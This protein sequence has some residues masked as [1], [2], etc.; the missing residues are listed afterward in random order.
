MGDTHTDEAFVRTPEI[1]GEFMYNKSSAE[2]VILR[3]L[4]LVSEPRSWIRGVSSRRANG[5]YC[6]VDD[7]D[8]AKF[9]L[10]GAID[11]AA[12]DTDVP[13]KNRQDA[14]EHVAFYAQARGFASIA[15]FND[16]KAVRHS[17]VI[18]ALCRGF[19]S[20]IQTRLM[21][22]EEDVSPSQIIDH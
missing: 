1:L 13:F 12:Q 5:Q 20:A 10:Y 6:N 2:S 17:D 14:I 3:A 21:Y 9:C 19:E 11:R 22:E 8:A 16:H 15:E 7:P 4:E 18:S